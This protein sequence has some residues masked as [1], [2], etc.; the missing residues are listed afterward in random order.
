MALDTVQLATVQADTERGQPTMTPPTPYK[1]PSYNMAPEDIEA[2]AALAS[3][4]YGGNKSAALR[5]CVAVGAIVLADP[6]TFG[7]TEA[8]D[9][10]KR[11]ARAHCPEADQ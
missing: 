10:V 7:V 9:V 2:L 4:R 6:A 11:Y 1:R 8:E 5:D 3:I